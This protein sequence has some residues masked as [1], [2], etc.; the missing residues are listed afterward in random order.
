[1]LHRTRVIVFLLL[2]AAF[3]VGGLLLAMQEEIVYYKTPQELKEVSFSKNLRLGGIVETGSL[4]FDTNLIK[5]AVTDQIHSIRVEFEGILPD[6]FKEGK[7]VVAQG[8]LEDGVF[9]ATKLL[10]KHDENYTPE[11]RIYQNPPVKNF[12]N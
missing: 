8:T 7:G 1:M 12:K 6:L 4:T 2:G 9:K 5:F 11:K 3:L 10:A